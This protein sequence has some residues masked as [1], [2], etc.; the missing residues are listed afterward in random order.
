MRLTH[1]AIA[2]TLT[3]LVFTGYLAW[4]GQQTAKG[5][6]QELE[7][8]KKQQAA[9]NMAR[10]EASSMLPLPTVPAVSIAPPPAAGT[11]A[12]APPLM[13][14]TSAL[15]GGGLTVPKE[16]LEAEAKGVNTNTLRPMQKQV[17]AAQPVAKV[18]TIVKD[19]GFVI[20]DAGSKQG[21]AK[22]QKYEIRRDSAVLG[23]VT[24]TDSIEESEAVADLDFASIPAGVSIEPGDELIKPTGN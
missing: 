9:R 4:E 19:Q 23:K 1:I 24:V 5:A 6:M 18:K 10:P 3:L 14:G 2:L 13:A 16:V 12:E 7:F 8:L 21:I 15:P 11:I 20:I 17:L 22:G